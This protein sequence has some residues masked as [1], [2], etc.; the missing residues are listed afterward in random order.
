MNV[1]RQLQQVLFFI[2]ANR[3]EASLKQRADS[4]VTL[5]DRFGVGQK[6]RLH[7]ICQP[8]AFEENHQVI[9]IGHQAICNDIKDIRLE[10]FSHLGQKVQIVLALKKDV[11]MIVAAIVQMVVSACKELRAP[12]GHVISNPRN[13]FSSR[14]R[15]STFPQT[16][17]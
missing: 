14:K 17:F 4:L 16:R 10:I 8:L 3:F 15:V 2:H 7:Q 5:I 6:K 9:M 13:P 1:P 11:L 12:R